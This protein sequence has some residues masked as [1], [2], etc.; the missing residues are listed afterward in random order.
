MNESMALEIALIGFSF[1]NKQRER[2]R[3][4]IST[5][6]LLYKNIACIQANILMNID[7]HILNKISAN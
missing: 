7:A 5:S 6:R 4:V 3:R 2:E 1:L